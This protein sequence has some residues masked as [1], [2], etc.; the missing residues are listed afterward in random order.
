MPA[1]ARTPLQTATGPTV[2][3]RR[4]L[5]TVF[6][7]RALDRLEETLLVPERKVLY[8][9]SAR[10]HDVTQSLLG[11][12]AE[13]PAR[14]RRAVLP[15]AAP[16]A[17][18]GSF[19]RGSTR[20]DDDA[21]RG[22]VGWPG[23]RRRHQPAESK[24]P[25]HAGGLWRCRHA[26]HARDRLGAG[27]CLPREACWET[28]NA[29]AALPLRT[30]AMLQRRPTDSGLRSISRR[31]N[32]C[33]SCISSRT[34]ATA[35][36]CKSDRQTPG[37]D[38]A[39]NLASFRNLLILN[40]DGSDPAAAA[41]LIEKSV[42]A[43]RAG[44]G[45]VLLRLIVPRL[46]GHSGQD[47]QA[48]KTPEE[49]SAEQARDPLLQL[50]GQIVPRIVPEAEWKAIE[51]EAAGR[52]RGSACAHRN[53]ACGCHGTGRTRMHSPRAARMVRPICSS[54]VACCARAFVPAAGSN[55]PQSEGPRIN[56]LTAIRRTLEHELRYQ[57]ARADFRRGR[58]A[59]GRCARGDAWLCRSDSGSSGSSTPAC[60]RRASSAARS[61]WRWRA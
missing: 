54:R 12:A 18:T 53:H 2:D 21:G 39:A 10:G 35:S 44:E 22:H 40:G 29:T 1:S 9:F 46:S 26:V 7:S 47:T 3:W 52:S 4:V 45:P 37:G 42:A 41:V 55:L 57:S 49:V 61:A 19:R 16:R 14:R 51:T 20:L 11:I 23:H 17:R 38:I 8:Q 5:H 15:V 59:Q 28:S 25:M 48:Y 58:R 30:A 6:L 34:T 60:R 27:A 13:W 32:A 24:G 50:R 31:R 43:V 56:M 33:H 36:R